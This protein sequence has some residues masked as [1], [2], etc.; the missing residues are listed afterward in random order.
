[1]PTKRTQWGIA[2]PMLAC[3]VLCGCGSPAAAGNNQ[4]STVH[5]AVVPATAK[6]GANGTAGNTT[7]LTDPSSA[8]ST[9]GETKP[10]GSHAAYPP[11]ATRQVVPELWS[12]PKGSVALT[13]DDG[14]SPYTERILAVLEKYHVRATFFFIGNRVNLWPNAVRRAVADG[15]GI[16]N[17]S[18]SHPLFTNLSPQQQAQQIELAEQHIQA[19]DPNPVTL[20]RPPYGAFN[21]ATEQILQQDHMMLALWN[22]D[23]RDWAASKPQQVIQAVVNGNPSGGVF[24]LHDNNMTLQALPTII[25]DLQKRGLKFV[26]LGEP[27]ATVAEPIGKDAVGGAGAGKGGNTVEGK[28]GNQ[29]VQNALP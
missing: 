12:V 4:T 22:R 1:M 5:P 26:V 19:L 13:I 8:T 6:V 14:P 9:S 17:H 10:S 25:E 28:H 7:G 23:P 27:D 18:E 2:L 16:G 11:Y 20:F 15:D 24:D 3:A 29:T 21:D